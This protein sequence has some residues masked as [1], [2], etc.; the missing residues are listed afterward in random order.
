MD[1][2]RVAPYG[3][4][5]D[6]VDIPRYQSLGSSRQPMNYAQVVENARHGIHAN[7]DQIGDA[8]A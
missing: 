4:F 8:E 2:R 7:Q 6:R 1:S 3:H 5:T